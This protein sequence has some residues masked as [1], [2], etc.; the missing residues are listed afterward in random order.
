MHSFKEMFRDVSPGW[1]YATMRAAYRGFFWVPRKARA[2]YYLLTRDIPLDYVDES[3]DEYWLKRQEGIGSGVDILRDRF[4]LAGAHIPLG[5]SVVDIG[6]GDGTFLKCLIE[7]DPS[8]KVLGIDYSQEAVNLCLSKG[9]PAARYDLL[10]G[11]HPEGTFDFV[12]A[13][14]VIEHIPEAEKFLTICSSLC[15]ENGRI[16]I[17]VPN[18]GFI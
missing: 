13:L 18:V 8:K 16:I 1:L 9:I 2:I 6:C 5:S 14:E 11:E 3:Y 12:V 7:R 15:P 17:S 4:L 10:S